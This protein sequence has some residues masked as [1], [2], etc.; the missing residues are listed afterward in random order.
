MAFGRGSRACLAEVFLKFDSAFAASVRGALLVRL[1]KT[2]AISS[3]DPRQS[4]IHAATIWFAVLLLLHLLSI[5]PAAY[6]QGRGVLHPEI[7]DIVYRPEIRLINHYATLEGPIW[8]FAVGPY[9][10]YATACLREGERQGP[11]W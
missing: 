5:G 10:G 4:T 7:V 9:S 6:L 2:P 3:E 8:D 1:V 11:L